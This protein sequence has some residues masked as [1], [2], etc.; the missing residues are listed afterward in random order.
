M[1]KLST[2]KTQL[3]N[4]AKKKWIYENFWQKE[5][6]D[7]CDEFAKTY[8][9]QINYVNSSSPKNLQKLYS[10]YVAFSN[11]AQTFDLSKLK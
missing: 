1:K 7:W 3:I 2:I 11:W 10:E 4:K 5:L 9:T 8:H 6:R